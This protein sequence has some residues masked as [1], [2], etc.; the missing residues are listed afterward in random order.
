MRKLMLAILLNLLVLAP[1]ASAVVFFDDFS[2]G[3]SKWNNERGSW[4]AVSGVY[5]A[6]SPDNVPPTYSSAKTAEALTDFVLDVDVN[7]VRDGGLWLR[8]SY[9]PSGVNGVLLV[10]GGYGG[11]FN[12][13]YWHILNNDSYS[14][15]MNAAAY[16]GSLLGSNA[17]IQVVVS[18][19]EYKA[20]VN[21]AANPLTTLTTDSFASGY[22]GLYDFSGQTF[23]NVRIEYG[24]S[25]VPEPATMAL[26]GVGLAG[27]ALRRR[28]V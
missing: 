11:S 19:N 7:A 25:A 13:L 24:A 28:R 20:Y 8:S 27:L 12:G 23:D 5:D 4:Q 2:S 1:S 6:A 22:V 9:G 21:G 3:A 15:G 17:H 18:G 10:T 16:S 26:F 14:S